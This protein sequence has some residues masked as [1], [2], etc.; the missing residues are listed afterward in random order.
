MASGSEMS[1]DETKA[2]GEVVGKTNII[3][4]NATFV[5]DLR[6]LTEAQKEVA[7]AKMRTIVA[8]NLTDTRAEITFTYGLPGMS[9]TYGN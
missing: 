4:P 1:Y 5:G 9:P 2:R 7:R 3:V 8:Q 6:F